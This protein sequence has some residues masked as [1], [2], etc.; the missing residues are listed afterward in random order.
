MTS[1]FK[2]LPLK[3]L[4]L[5]IGLMSLSGWADNQ[6]RFLQQYGLGS[7]ECGCYSPNGR[8]LITGGGGGGV[9]WDIETGQPIR[10]F[11]EPGHF[12]ISLA[13]SPD[14]TQV[15]TGGY[16][17]KAILWEIATGRKIQSFSNNF[18]G[19]RDSVFSAAFT[20][21]GTKILTGY[22][23]GSAILWNIESGEKI[24]IFSEYTGSVYSV[25]VS[26]DGTKA[27]TGNSHNTANLWNL[28][29]GEII[30]T[31]RKSVV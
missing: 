25:A 3:V 23:S 24:R 6:S 2:C 29:T 30:R 31:D 28:S 9:V 21:D 20:P 14:G 19:W 16:N 17:G 15:L 12:V 1:G 5:L 18:Y 11:R 26:P 13:V 4:A 22:G 27:L 7:L 8:H 10:F